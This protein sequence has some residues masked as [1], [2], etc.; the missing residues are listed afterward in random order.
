MSVAMVTIV[1]VATLYP[2]SLHDVLPQ[3]ITDWLDEVYPPLSRLA[4]VH[5][6]L[7]KLSSEELVSIQLPSVSSGSGKEHPLLVW[8]FPILTELM[9]K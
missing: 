2:S 1:T 6:L 5:G 7:A 8:L 3:Y 9:D 4:I